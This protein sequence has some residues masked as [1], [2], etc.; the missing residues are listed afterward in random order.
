MKIT[1][2]VSSEKKPEES[3]VVL[4]RDDVLDDGRAGYGV[5]PGGEIGRGWSRWFRNIHD[6][7]SHVFT[8][9]PEGS[10]E[11]TNYECLKRT[12]YTVT[13]LG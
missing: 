4:I 10:F 3:T 12:G 1:I 9:L 5:Y 13:S 7:I 6:A 8:T 2:E 11:G